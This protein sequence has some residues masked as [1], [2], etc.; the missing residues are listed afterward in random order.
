MNR[1]LGRATRDAYGDF[2]VAHGAVDPNLVVLDAD[3]SKSTRTAKFGARFP[4]RFFNVGIVESTM[5]GIAAGLALSGKTPFISS[6]A[7]FLLCKSYDQMRISVSFSD[8]PVKFVGS[9]GG[10]SIGEDG[11]SQMSIEDVALAVT[12]PG[13]SVVVP[14]DEHA[15]SA[16]LPEFARRRGPGYMRVGRTKAPFVYTPETAADL[17]I[18]K[19]ARLR[20]GRDVAIFA[21]GLLVFEALEAAERLA[22]EGIEAAVLDLHTVKPLDEEAVEEAARLGAAVACEEHSIHG[23]LCSAVADALGRRR[24]VPLE[25]VAIEDTYAESGTPEEL[26]V[27][28]GLTAE[29]V[30]EAARRAVARKRKTGA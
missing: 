6:F 8:A 29:R 21:N 12:L 27:R 19:A 16:L 18:G 20:P 2:L 14:A 9:H 4:D 24:P 1:R 7:S 26:L 25:R 3:L 23:G 28:Y 17:R 15:A 10:I 13:F 11:P 22:A 30:A 5:T